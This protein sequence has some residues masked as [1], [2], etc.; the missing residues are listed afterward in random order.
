[1]GLSEATGLGAW[2]GAPMTESWGREFQDFLIA[3]KSGGSCLG[4]ATGRRGVAGGPNME[5][6]WPRDWV[7]SVAQGWG[8]SSGRDLVA[9]MGE[10]R[11]GSLDPTHPG[12]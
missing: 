12:H 1:M 9:Q 2:V 6:Q 5:T 8:G 10:I 3:G 4:G 7:K 11:F